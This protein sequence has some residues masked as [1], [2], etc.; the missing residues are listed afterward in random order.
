M[1]LEH[2]AC[3]L[4]RLPAREPAFDHLGTQAMPGDPGRLWQLSSRAQSR[5]ALPQHR[6]VSSSNV[7]HSN[8]S[9]AFVNTRVLARSGRTRCLP[10]QPEDL[11]RSLHRSPR[12]LH[13]SHANLTNFCCASTGQ[14]LRHERRLSRRLSA[15]AKLAATSS[16]AVTGCWLAHQRSAQHVF[17]HPCPVYEHA[18]RCSEPSQR[19]PVNTSRV[20]TGESDHRRLAA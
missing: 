3:G 10:D 19:M 12:S 16:L 5:Q 9:G 11:R 18:A 4:G 6:D 15:R 8:L 14:R 17:P 1:A 20:P 7:Q 2:L 13:A